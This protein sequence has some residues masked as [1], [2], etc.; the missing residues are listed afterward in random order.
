MSVYIFGFIISIALFALS[1]KVVKKQRWV[2]AVPAILIPCLI[3]GFR[4]A[5]IGVDTEGYLVPMAKAA[6]ASSSYKD[7]MSSSWFRIWRNLFVKDYEYG[8][9]FVVYVISKLFK[10]IVAVQFVVQLLTV[11][12]IYVASYVSKYKT[13]I[14]M[15]VYYFIFFNTSL[16][17]MRQ[18][19]AVSFGIL[20]VQY[21][22]EENKKL[23]FVFFVVSFLFHYSAVIVFIIVCIYKFV[24]SEGRN[25]NIVG[26]PINSYYRNMSIVMVVG[27]VIVMGIGVIA[28]I[29]PYIGLGRYIYYLVGS[30]GGVQFLPTQI[31]TRLPILLLFIFN[32]KSMKKNETNLRFYFVMIFL[33]ILVAQL[34]S[35]NTYS[36]RIAIYFTVFGILSYASLCANTKRKFLVSSCTFAYLIFYWWYFYVFLGRDSTIPY[37]AL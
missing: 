31:L 25:V 26:I 37:I 21:F 2:L 27:L 36:G 14:C 34:A 28:K 7:Y 30:S 22:M 15:S 11:F 12:P 16:N 10:S 4:A 13:W 23:F 18:M 32:W 20:A 9:S 5:S 6:M 24:Q 17:M 1:D 29:L 33:D 3:A 19:I 35:V 8:F